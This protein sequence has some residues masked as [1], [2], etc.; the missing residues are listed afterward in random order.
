MINKIAKDKIE[1][2][3]NVITFFNKSFYFI[4]SFSS[5]MIEQY[6]NYDAIILDA[7]DIDFTRIIIKKF[8]S[9]SKIEFYLKN[10]SIREKIAK[11]GYNTIQK[12]SYSNLCKEIIG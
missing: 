10:D 8:R 5:L 6:E 9:H 1:F 3:D 4:E 2:K 7:R 12:Y 11:N